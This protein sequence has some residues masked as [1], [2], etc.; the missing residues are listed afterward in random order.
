MDVFH[1]RIHSVGGNEDEPTLTIEPEEEDSQ[2][3]VSQGVEIEEGIPRLSKKRKN[4][5]KSKQL[6]TKKLK[7]ETNKEE[8][9]SKEDE[10]ESEEV[11]IGIELSST[12][13]STIT[14]NMATT[15]SSFLTL[16]FILERGKTTCPPRICFSKLAQYPLFML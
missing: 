7:T 4:K 11:E 2:V 8:H 15:C 3:E 16:G 12:L 9:L 1:F 13:V 5:E 10:D 6:K 14:F